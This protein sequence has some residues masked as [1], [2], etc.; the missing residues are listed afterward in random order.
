MAIL[1]GAAA[2]LVAFAIGSIWLLASGRVRR[3]ESRRF[4]LTIDET[5]PISVVAPVPAEYSDEVTA[6]T[7][8][9]L[10]QSTRDT[11]PERLRRA[12]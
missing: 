1:V 5:L 9:P 7:P 2:A 3:D 12:G 11:A 8:I 10:P 6:T 4:H